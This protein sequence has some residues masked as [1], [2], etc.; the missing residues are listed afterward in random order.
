MND[1]KSCLFHSDYKRSRG[2]LAN[3]D[4]RD[5]RRDANSEGKEQACREGLRIIILGA[6]FRMVKIVLRSENSVIPTPYYS[7]LSLF[8]LPEL[9]G[10][11]GV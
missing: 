7:Y 4:R 11:V 2:L 9:L 5:A 3:S 1:D 10:T 6:I 8:Q